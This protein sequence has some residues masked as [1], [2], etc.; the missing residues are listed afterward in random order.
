MQLRAAKTVGFQPA[1]ESHQERTDKEAEHVEQSGMSLP[2]LFYPW[3]F[4]MLMALIARN[5]ICSELL[6]HV[7]YTILSA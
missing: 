7:W 6:S 5:S 1:E 4:L 2:P 3:K